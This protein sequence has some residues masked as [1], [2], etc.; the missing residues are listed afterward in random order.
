MMEQLQA[1]LRITVICYGLLAILF[2]LEVIER[3]E[4]HDI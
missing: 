4:I 3:D 2:I 1:L